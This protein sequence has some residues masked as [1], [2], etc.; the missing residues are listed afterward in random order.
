MLDA[1]EADGPE[2]IV[3]IGTPGQGGAQSI[4]L[5]GAVLNKLGCTM[6]DVQSEINDWSPGVYITFGRF[7][8]CASNDDWFHSELIII[9]GNNPAYSNIATYHYIN[10]ARYRG[11]QVVTIAPDYSPSSIHSDL[12]VPVRIGSD[13]ALA[14]AMCRVIINEGLMDREFVRE[15]TDL[16]LLVRVDKGA[17]C[18]TATSARAAA[19]TS[20]T[21]STRSRSRS[22]PRRARWHS[23][24]SSRRCAARGRSRS[25]T[26]HRSR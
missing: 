23:G 20:F 1:I 11:A 6:T 18:A 2:S 15:Q 25:V 22:S 24:T 5:A 4:A 16:P 3:R 21:C 8:P 12:H 13:A 14:L 17:S 10:E 26:A 9:W 7:D 19:R